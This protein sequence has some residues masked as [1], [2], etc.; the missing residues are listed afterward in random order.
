[1]HDLT[2]AK[3]IVSLLKEKLGAGKGHSKASVSVVLGPFTHVTPE[4]LRSAFLLLNEKEGFNDVSLDIKKHKAKIR[5]KKCRKEIETASPLTSC[6]FCGG[7]EIDL[8]NGE[9]FTIES[10]EIEQD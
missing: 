2:F 4:S 9:E 6:P 10:I 3:R 8:L 1:M 5:C 7:G